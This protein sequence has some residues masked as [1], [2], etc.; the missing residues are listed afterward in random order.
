ML[1]RAP[2]ML[3]AVAALA[4]QSAPEPSSVAGTVTNSVTGVPVLRAH[5]TLSCSLPDG[6]QT[7]GALTDENGR[8]SLSPLPAGRCFL[9]AERVGFVPANRVHSSIVELSAGTHKEGV[10]FILMPTRSHYR[11]RGERR[12]RTGAGRPGVG[13]KQAFGFFGR[14]RHGRGGPISNLGT[15]PG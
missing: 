11:P 13:G 14:P 3:A 2:A 7:Y 9:G 8:F 15:A 12:G 4:A 5:V 1:A 10:K 6:Q